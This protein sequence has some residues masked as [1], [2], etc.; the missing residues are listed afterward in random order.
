MDVF[1]NERKSNCVCLKCSFVSGFRRVLFP[2]GF[3]YLA[4]EQPKTIS[5]ARY[6]KPV[7]NW[8]LRLA[9]MFIRFRIPKSPVPDRLRIPGYRAT[10]NNLNS[11]VF[12][13]CREQDSASASNVHSFPDSEESCSRQASNTWL[14]RLFSVARFSRRIQ[15]GLS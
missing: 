2:T 12:E 9:Q 3:E 8:T 4:I 7:G 1:L 15:A 6:S 14:L 10:E 11:Q 13:A 5:I